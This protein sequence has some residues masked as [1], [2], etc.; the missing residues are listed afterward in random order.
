MPNQQRIKDENAR[1][2]DISNTIHVH[3]VQCLAYIASHATCKNNYTG[4]G[5]ITLTTN[6]VSN[7]LEHMPIAPNNAFFSTSACFH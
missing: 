2:A 3:A 7:A 5:R 1:P 6:K 4:N